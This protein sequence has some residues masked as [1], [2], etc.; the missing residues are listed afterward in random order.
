MADAPIVTQW[1]LEVKTLTPLHVGAGGPRL[2]ADYDFLVRR[3]EVLV[4]DTPGVLAQL[5]DEELERGVEPRISALLRPE[6]YDAHVRYRLTPRG[7]GAPSEIVPC[8]RD[9]EDRPYLPGSS[10]KGALRTVLAWALASERGQPLPLERLQPQ[11]KFAA[12]EL[13]RQLFGST[14]HRDLL[15]ALRVTDLRPADPVQTELTTVAVY[16]LRGDQLVPKGPGYRWAVE[17]LPAGTRLQG[18]I[19]LDEYLF[20]PPAQELPFSQQRRR[21]AELPRAARGFVRELARRESRFF[22]EH[23][24]PRVG[25]FYHRLLERIEEMEQRRLEVGFLQLGWGTGWTAKTL[26]LALMADPRFPQ[27]VQRYQ[28]DS[29]RNAGVFPKTRRLVERGNTA[30]E[31]PGWITFRLV[32]SGP[33]ARRGEPRQRA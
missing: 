8:V 28:L 12:A 26:G 17:T 27:L 30:E 6:Q 15:R 29:R 13:E 7:G 5:S 23:G 10:F 20:S 14:P 32:R 18:S 16:S 1:Q 3:G 4:F 24:Q 2:Q 9:V 11:P 31:P 22:S 21:L 33:A 19:T 25:Q